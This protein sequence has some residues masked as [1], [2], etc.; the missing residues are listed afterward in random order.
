MAD[1][2]VTGQV[3][4][5]PPK[6]IE[7]QQGCGCGKSYNAIAQRI[8]GRLNKVYKTRYKVF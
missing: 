4:A 6:A 2:Q 8:K 1:T 7:P 5:N 3:I